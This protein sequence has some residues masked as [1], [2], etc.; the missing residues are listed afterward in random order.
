MASKTDP[1]DMT[2]ERKLS[3]SG[4]TKKD[5][6]QLKIKFINKSESKKLGH[7]E[8][9]G[10]KIPY[11]APNG[12]DTGFYR[13]R[14]LGRLNGFKAYTEKEQRYTQ[15]A[16]TL[17]SIYLPHIGNIKWVEVF[18]NPETPIFITE[19]EFKAASATKFG[20]PTIGLGG[21]YAW[22]SPRA[23]VPFLDELECI[24]WVGR[25]VYTVF[26]SDLT[27]NINV[28][29]ALI[30]LCRMLTDR[31]ALPHVVHLPQINN[32]KVGLDDYLVKHKTE[33]FMELVSKA[34]IFE[35]AEALWKFNQEV[36]LIEQPPMILRLRDGMKMPAKSF[37]EVIYSNR[38]FYERTYDTQGNAKLKKKQLAPEWLKWEHRY[39]LENLTYEPGKDNVINGITYNTW[40]GWGV[41]PKKGDIKPWRDLISHLFNNN[42][43]AIHWF[44]CWCAVQFQQPGIKLTTAV[45]M[46][47]LHHGTGK[48]FIGYTLGKIF[49]KNFTEINQKHIHVDHN[50]WSENKQFVLGDDIT[51]S[52][53]RGDADVLKGMITRKF[54]RINIKYIPSYDVPDCINYFF[55]SNQPDSF[56]IEDRDRRYYIWEVENRPLSNDF[57]IEYE[58]WYNNSGPKALFDY[59][60][61]F[62]LG[63]FNPKAPAPLTDAKLEMIRTVKSDLGN[64]VAELMES[65]EE[66]LV[67]SGKE[68][69]SD[70][71][72]NTQLLMM[73]DP[74]NATRVTATGIG[75]ELR[76]AGFP[77]VTVKLQNGVSRMYI[78]RNRD[79]WLRAGGIKIAEHWEQHFGQKKPKF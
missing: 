14:Y 40:P 32:E 20:F 72:T 45:V 16:N 65:P 33:K 58:N 2:L 68:L 29:K 19:G 77:K 70:V 37:K 1:G 61:N 6:T 10:I 13:V 43:E 50:E 56:F 21:V 4:L 5:A 54:V 38:H 35:D 57:Y 9:T 71:Y 47:G 49:G 27:T 28:Q 44:E 48:S 67:I 31:G 53:K 42:K 63:S 79:R 51:G 73:Y 55:T 15:P 7:E 12:K 41:E 17:P 76:R 36:V 60:L 69:K 18:K 24:E 75:R 66:K 46:W 30:H 8:R 74:E 22:R 26:D 39:C 59:F 11:L 78:V 23:N 64:W 3:E 25:T 34:S 62:N 52:D